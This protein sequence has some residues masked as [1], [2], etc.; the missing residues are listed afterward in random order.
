M[1]QDGD[2][3]IGLMLVF[4]GFNQDQVFF[5]WAMN[6]KIPLYYLLYLE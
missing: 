2:F 6:V 1:N 3:S 4:D 5:N